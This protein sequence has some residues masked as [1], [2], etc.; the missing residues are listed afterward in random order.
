MNTR[1]LTLTAAISSVMTSLFS[2][3]LIF[4]L[5]LG[6]SVREAYAASCF[7]DTGGHWAEA[8]ICWMKTNGLSSGYLDGTFR[9]DNTIT[10][11]EVASLFYHYA[12]SGDAYFSTPLS[13]W[14]LDYDTP[15]LAPRNYRE[16]TRLEPG[17]AGTFLYQAG[18]V[19]QQSE[20]NQQMTIK[21][22]EL[23]YVANSGAI[24]GI[25]L[26]LTG[27]NG[28][29]FYIYDAVVDNTVRSDS[30]CRTYMFASPDLLKA[31]MS[32]TMVVSLNPSSSS[33]FTDI[34]SLTA[35][36]GYTTNAAALAPVGPV[37]AP[38]P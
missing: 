11:A 38:A 31:Q 23:C 36:E 14:V 7:T 17:S 12:T 25:E 32:L 21:G 19:M 5:V 16:I 4:T 24:N 10:R 37:H 15:G 2:A 8:F 29:I 22:A 13:A 35:I 3:I 9:P 27:I 1:A 6:F 18:M 26:E 30:A 33:S 20:H 34:L 28:P